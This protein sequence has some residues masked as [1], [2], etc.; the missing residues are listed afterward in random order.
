MIHPKY[1]WDSIKTKHNYQ[2]DEIISGLQKSIRRGNEE[3][4][5]NCGYEMMISGK[6]L[7]E[8]FWERIRVISVEDIGLANPQLITIIFTLYQNFVYLKNKEDR[9]LQG[10]IAIL[11]LTR[12]KKSRYVDELYNDLK[13][14][15]TKGNFKIKIPDY[16]LDFHTKKGREKGRNILHFWKEAAKIKKDIHKNNKK[17]YLNIL[18][19]YNT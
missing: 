7:T 9:F 11:L 12:S 19:K 14:N 13:I 18:K 16:V 3:N 17:H 10:I 2:A 8:K 5:I 6:E 15:D 1:Y 4:A